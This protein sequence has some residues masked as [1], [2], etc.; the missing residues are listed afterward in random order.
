MPLQE[1]LAQL[2]G[3]HSTKSLQL[4]TTSESTSEADLPHSRSMPFPGWLSLTDWSKWQ[5]EGPAISPD[6]GQPCKATLAPEVTDNRLAEVCQ[7]YSMFN[8]SLWPSYCPL[9]FSQVSISNNHRLQILSQLL[10]LRNWNCDFLNVFSP[11]KL[12]KNPSDVK[13]QNV[14]KNNW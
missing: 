13:R 1:E 11:W 14:S 9:S 8:I 5:C 6:T 4:F 10:L 12:N 7:A 2:Q 3:L